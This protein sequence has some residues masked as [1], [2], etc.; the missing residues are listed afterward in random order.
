MLVLCQL[1]NGRQQTL[2]QQVDAN[3]LVH[4]QGSGAQLSK[5][6]A[7]V[8]AHRVPHIER[9]IYPKPYD[10]TLVMQLPTSQ[11]CLRLSVALPNSTRFCSL[12]GRSLVTTYITVCTCR[13]GA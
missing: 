8:A 2:R 1:L 11:H 3:H 7:V 5:D 12:H 4:L 6:L 10:L 9:D 13:S